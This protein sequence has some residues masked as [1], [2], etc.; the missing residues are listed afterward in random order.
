MRHIKRIPNLTRLAIVALITLTDFRPSHAAEKLV[1]SGAAWRWLRGAA[2]P[3]S[4]RSLWCQPTFND[5]SWELAPTPFYY[6]NQGLQGTQLTDMQGKYSSICLR[7]HF[8]VPT[9]Q[10]Q[11]G[12]KVDFLSDDGFI[13]WI[14]GNA[15][16]K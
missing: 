10:D 6:G 14:N 9:L 12:L 13:L 16:K 8:R 3:S 4:P 5:S 15:V 1:S 7:T 11:S 2:E